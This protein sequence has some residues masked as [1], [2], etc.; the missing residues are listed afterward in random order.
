M[1][2]TVFLLHVVF[3]SFVEQTAAAT[4]FKWQSCHMLLKG[5][6]GLPRGF[7]HNRRSCRGGYDSQL[8]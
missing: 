5:D 4:V 1:E 2:Q 7:Q 8:S 6:V 3:E